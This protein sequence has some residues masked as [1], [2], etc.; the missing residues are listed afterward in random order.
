MFNEIIYIENKCTYRYNLS[1]FLSSGVYP[2]NVGKFLIL[3]KKLLRLLKG[4]K[5]INKRSLNVIQSNFH[6]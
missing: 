1:I 5:I 3:Y 6:N 4:F 2:S